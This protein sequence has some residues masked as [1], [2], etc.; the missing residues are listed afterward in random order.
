MIC[1]SNTEIPHSPVLFIHDLVK[2]MQSPIDEKS[3][4][5]SDH[6]SIAHDKLDFTLSG[7]KTID[8][9]GT[10]PSVKI[11]GGESPKDQK[12]PAQIKFDPLKFKVVHFN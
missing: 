11:P 9:K 6:S 7:M 4:M 3:T 12:Y 5:K 2:I 1:N 10:K 8:T